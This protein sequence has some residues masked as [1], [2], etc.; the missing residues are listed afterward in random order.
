MEFDI[1]F[2]KFVGEVFV[3][4]DYCV[5]RYGLYGYDVVF[6]FVVYFGCFGFGDNFYWIFFQMKVDCVGI[7]YNDIGDYVVIGRCV[8]NLLIMQVFRQMNCV[9]YV[10]V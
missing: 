7:M 9:K 6:D 8:I 10:C 2:C 4:L 1:G 5:R 3:S